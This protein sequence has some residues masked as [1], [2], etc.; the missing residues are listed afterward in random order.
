M[1][2][3]IIE[4]RK[5]KKEAAGYVPVET[6]IEKKAAYVC[7]RLNWSRNKLERVCYAEGVNTLYDVLNQKSRGRS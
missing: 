4:G 5:L 3:K 1:F 6:D 2:E 7:N